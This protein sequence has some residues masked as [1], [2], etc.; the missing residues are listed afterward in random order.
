MQ[1]IRYGVR[2]LWK[3]PGF[4]IISVL[5]LA[6]GIGANSAIFSVVNAVLLRPLPFEE[7]ERL[8][9]VLGRNER[10]GSTSGAHSYL[11]FSDLRDQNQVFDS[12]GAYTASTFFFI[13]A[14]GP[15]R[16]NGALLSTDMFTVL[17]V[18]PALGRAFTREE[19]QLGAKRVAL[20]SHQLWQRRFG[21]D[22]KV[23][24]QE[25]TVGSTPTTIIGVMPK[26]FKFPI[27]M[28]A[29][30]WMPLAPALSEGIIQSRGAVFLG[31]VARIKQGVSMKQAQAEATTIASRLA[32]QY[33]ESNTGQSI[34]LQSTHERLVGDL[35]PALLVILGAVG[36]VL[37]IACANVANLLLARA[38][39][40]E[41]EIALRTALGAS[42]TRVV[43]QLLTESLL[44]ALMGS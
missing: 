19:D 9:T 41:K 23:L 2:M 26:G 18:R 16:V 38:A 27:S 43:R 35:R 6:L 32:T 36:F 14:E 15:E 10:E 30:C 3:H 24:G 13:G 17:R 42:R 21:G 44:L 29:D 28:D 5:A 1:D 25:V 4:T 37:L 12:V 22:P 11:N 34:V 20:I 40:R 7:P 33:P 8:V 31:V 39:A